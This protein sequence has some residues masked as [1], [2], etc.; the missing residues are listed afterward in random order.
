MK[1][2]LVA[3]I[4]TT[5]TF[6]VDRDRCIGFM[7]DEGRVYATPYMIRDIEQTCRDFLLEHIDDSEDSVGT[8]VDVYHTGA[9]VE[10]DK[11][12]VTITVTE[13]KGRAVTMDVAVKDS[14]EDVGK[15]THSRFVVDKQKTFERLSAKRDKVLGG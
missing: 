1:D 3:G 9:T 14:L 15:G 6:D 2:S 12:E 11:V 4:T 8:H 5:R 13:V 7:G 10:G